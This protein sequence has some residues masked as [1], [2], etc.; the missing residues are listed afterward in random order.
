MWWMM[1]AVD[2]EKAT[3]RWRKPLLIYF[4]IGRQITALA[5]A[6][7]KPKIQSRMQSRNS[8]VQS[9]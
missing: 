5:P 6:P 1:D 7:T 2:E 4:S 8:I 3:R 9:D